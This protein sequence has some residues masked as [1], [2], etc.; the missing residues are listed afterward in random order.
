VGSVSADFLVHITP[1]KISQ[2]NR[3]ALESYKTNM[4]ISLP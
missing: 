4:K 3:W 1:G 2:L